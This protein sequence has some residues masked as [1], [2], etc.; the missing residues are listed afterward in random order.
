MWQVVRDLGGVDLWVL[1]LLAG[2]CRKVPQLASLALPGRLR[3]PTRS[4]AVQ[5]RPPVFNAFGV[6]LSLGGC[7]HRILKESAGQWLSVAVGL[8]PGHFHPRRDS[9]NGQAVL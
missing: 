3:E 7:G 1:L 6:H 2:Q 8:Q 5:L 4:I 9:S